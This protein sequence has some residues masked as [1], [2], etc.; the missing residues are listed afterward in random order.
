MLFKTSVTVKELLE[1][2]KAKQ[3]L[4]VTEGFFGVA[5]PGF[6]YAR[7][8]K[9]ELLDRDSDEIIKDLVNSRVYKQDISGF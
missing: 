3:G 5:G 8:T 9:A 6:T 7:Y 2:L 1:L 4:V